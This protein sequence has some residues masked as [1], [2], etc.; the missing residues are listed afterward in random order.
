MRSGR[1]AGKLGAGGRCPPR[2]RHSPPVFSPPPARHVARSTR[3]RLRA[4]LFSPLRSPR[5]RFTAVWFTEQHPPCPLSTPIAST[6][7]PA[8]SPGPAQPGPGGHGPPSLSAV[9]SCQQHCGW[10]DSSRPQGPQPQPGPGRG[11][12]G[13]GAN[14]SSERVAGWV[15]SRLGSESES[16]HQ[17]SIDTRAPGCREM[18]R[19]VRHHSP[20]GAID[21][22]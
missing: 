10:D 16:S 3:P 1:T 5:C 11:S 13:S 22:D 17:R 9:T 15:K 2:S 6:F 20:R 18:P 12:S 21:R 19:S 4:P 14:S 8:A 7:K